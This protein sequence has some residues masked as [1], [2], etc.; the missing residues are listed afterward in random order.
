MWVI[1]CSFLLGMLAW[2]GM[3]I[4]GMTVVMMWHAGTSR[5]LKMKLD[6]CSHRPLCLYYIACM[7]LC[8]ALHEVCLVISNNL[9]MGFYFF[10][11]VRCAANVSSMAC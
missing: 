10:A 7:D 1:S 11:L 2:C 6:G 4:L 5:G 3:I 9:D 8:H